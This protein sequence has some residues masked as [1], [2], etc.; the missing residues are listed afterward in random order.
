LKIEITYNDKKVVIDNVSVGGL[1]K[2]EYVTADGKKK[3]YH[4]KITD[5]GRSVMN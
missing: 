5:N 4:I 3:I 2:W 1:I